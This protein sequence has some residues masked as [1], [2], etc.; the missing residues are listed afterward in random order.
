MFLR[1]QAGL[2]HVRVQPD[3]QLA[4]CLALFHHLMGCHDALEAKDGGNS[5]S[6]SRLSSSSL[7]YPKRE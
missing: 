1:G 6:L 5:I 4:A 7:Q 2:L 3:H